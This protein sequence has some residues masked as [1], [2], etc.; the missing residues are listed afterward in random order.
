[1]LG[2]PASSTARVGLG[3]L[4]PARAGGDQDYRGRLAQWPRAHLA[5]CLRHV[6]GSADRDPETGAARSRNPA[7]GFSEGANVPDQPIDLLGA[8]NVLVTV[9]PLLA[10][11]LH[12]IEDGLTHLVVRI[13]LLP[14]GLG[15][16]R[17]L[18]LH[19]LLRIAFPFRP[20]AG[21]TFGFPGSR[22]L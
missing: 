11:L 2:T 13:A 18:H 4:F 3:C 7:L 6:W 1:R 22:D 17:D 5:G 19:A 14:L 15:H 10:F 9:H 16:V 20:V 21:G 8:E 12:P